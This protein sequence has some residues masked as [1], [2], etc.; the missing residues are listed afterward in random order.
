M[1]IRV[2]VPF[3]SPAI[4][5][6]GKAEAEARRK[7]GLAQ[8]FSA[9]GSESQKL[10][11]AVWALTWSGTLP[12][13]QLVLRVPGLKVRKRLDCSSRLIVLRVSE[14]GA[15]IKPLARELRRSQELVME[16]NP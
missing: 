4:P 2:S 5:S 15:N 7:V 6:D 1:T 12:G 9:A 11:L 13:D 14:A 8:G 16:P 3:P 10:G